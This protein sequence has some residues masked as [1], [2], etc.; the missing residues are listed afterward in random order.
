MTFPGFTCIQ[1]Q[2]G[3]AIVRCP[4]T[5][6]SASGRTVADAYAGLHRLL[7]ERASV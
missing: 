2:D 6:L 7:S 5:G 4:H 3:T 1:T